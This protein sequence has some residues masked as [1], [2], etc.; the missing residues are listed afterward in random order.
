[1]PFDQKDA[2]GIPDRPSDIAGSLADHVLR[3]TT[4]DP[5]VAATRD[6]LA[7]MAENARLSGEQPVPSVPDEEVWEELPPGVQRVLTKDGDMAEHS[8]GLWTVQRSDGSSQQFGHTYFALSLGPF[9][10]VPSGR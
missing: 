2:P 3:Y 1:M 7:A 6:H 5:S 9:R 10:P 4:D 8:G